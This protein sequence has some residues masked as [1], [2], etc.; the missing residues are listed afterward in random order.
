MSKYDQRAVNSHF[1]TRGILY[2]P[3]L[4]K[5]VGSVNAAILLGQLL[6]WHGTGNRKDGWIYKT[7]EQMAYETGL[8]RTQQDNAI[9]KLK[10]FGLLKTKRAGTPAKRCFLLDLVTV[11]NELTRLQETANLECL[12]SPEEIAD[13]Q[14]TITKSTQKNTA[15]KSVSEALALVPKEIASEFDAFL[16]V[17]RAAQKPITGRGIELNIVKLEELYP[18]DFDSQKACLEQ[19]IARGWQGVFPLADGNS[20]EGV[21][22]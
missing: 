5:I 15:I 3:G 17:L 22:Y 2:Q 7:C 8:S 16:D 10:T 18:N 20:E 12:K 21:I 6:Y 4:V 14:Q 11:Q 13:N 1:T 9:D 19:S